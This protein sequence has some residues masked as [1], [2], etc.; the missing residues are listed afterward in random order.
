VFFLWGFL[1]F[2]V[3]GL[4]VFGGGVFWCLVGLFRHPHKMNFMVRL[5]LRFFDPPRRC[6]FPFLYSGPGAF[7]FS[8]ECFLPF[9]GTGV[10]R[11]PRVYC[12]RVP[13]LRMVL[14]LPFFF[15]D[16][17]T[18]L[19]LSG[20]TCVSRLHGRQPIV[21]GL[22]W[23]LFF[24]QI[25]PFRLQVFDCGSPC[26]RVPSFFVTARRPSSDP[27]GVKH[28]PPPY[29]FHA[30]PLTILVPCQWRLHFPFCI[31]S[32]STFSMVVCFFCLSQ[33]PFNLPAGC[34][35][36]QIYMCLWPPLDSSVPSFGT[37]SI[38]GLVL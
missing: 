1:V 13:L 28:P 33:A 26:G 19:L 7:S 31:Q 21:L 30:M 32:W 20:N 11:P 12:K 15:L 27:G 14:P 9:Q 23:L 5:M 37:L 17:L 24:R 8:L 2:F 25:L 38:H 10:F 29:H 34:T 3:F 4:G 22:G 35:H 18:D 36:D 6:Y 16:S